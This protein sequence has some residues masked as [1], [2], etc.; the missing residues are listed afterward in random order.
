MKI[1]FPEIFG[2]KS[3]YIDLRRLDVIGVL[4]ARRRIGLRHSVVADRIGVLD[5]RT[6]AG[7]QRC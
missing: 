1:S 7:M 5:E 2:P 6:E 3:R 4:G